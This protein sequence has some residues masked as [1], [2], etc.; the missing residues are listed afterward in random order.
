MK[1]LYVEDTPE[2]VPLV[3]TTLE[4]AGHVV[5][6]ADNAVDGLRL[7]RDNWPD[8]I[9]IDIRLKENELDGLAL[10]VQIRAD[11]GLRNTLM[12]A[13]TA[14][15]ISEDGHL[16]AAGCDGVLGKPVEPGDLLKRLQPYLNGRR[17]GERL[18]SDKVLLFMRQNSLRFVDQLSERIELLKKRLADLHAIQEELIRHERLAATGRLALTMAHEISNPLHA[19][20][21][22]LELLRSPTTPEA[23][24]QQYF[25]IALEQVARVTTSMDKILNIY[26]PEA[27]QPASVDLNALINDAVMLISRAAHDSNV[28]IKLP[29]FAEA[30]VVQ[31][32][33]ASI[34]Q[35]ILN[36]LLNAL[37]A[38]PD[39][40]TLSIEL[41]N[42]GMD[43]LISISDTGTG[44]LPDAHLFE[45][46]YTTKPR[47]HGLGLYVCWLIA[48]AN[49]A[50]INGFNNISGG[51]TFTLQLQKAWPQ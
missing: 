9:L 31:A 33:Y 17:D 22:A 49:H 23:E 40:G 43:I 42:V 24:R 5:F 15:T 7:A 30:V 6:I 1:F 25:D 37:D 12:L 16:L 18:P 10:A 35:L 50:A 46:F 8:V 51:A 21:G 14:G 2:Q 4:R 20:G 11:L 19:I 39:G 34:H 32:A 47:G 48:Q 3:Q 38:M 41:E 29:Q 26:T 28:V 13:L 45:A 27:E 44:L 36:L